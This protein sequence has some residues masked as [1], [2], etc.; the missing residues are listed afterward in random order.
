MYHKTECD[1]GIV[2]MNLWLAN[3]NR[4]NLMASYILKEQDV[5]L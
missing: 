1:L 5:Y 3:L 4:R 2:S